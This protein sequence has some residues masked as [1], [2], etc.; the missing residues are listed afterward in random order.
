MNR[1]QTYFGSSVIFC[2]DEIFIYVSEAKR[3][4]L[5][6]ASVPYENDLASMNAKKAA[7]KKEEERA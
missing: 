2:S 1:P 3:M 5:A 4:E 7:E 6:R